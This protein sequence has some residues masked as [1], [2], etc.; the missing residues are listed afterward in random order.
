M[1]DRWSEVQDDR[2]KEPGLEVEEH[3]YMHDAAVFATIQIASA[4]TDEQTTHILTLYQRL[5]LAVGGLLFQPGSDGDPTAA[6]CGTSPPCILE[7]LGHFSETADH[8]VWGQ[9]RQSKRLEQG[10]VASHHVI[11]RIYF[12]PMSCCCLQGSVYLLS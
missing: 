4:S 3:D 9:V 12:L 8:Y 10:R 2:Q 7:F 5:E 6:Q 11:H 1:P